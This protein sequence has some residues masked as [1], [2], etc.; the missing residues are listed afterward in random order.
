[1]IKKVTGGLAHLQRPVILAGGKPVRQRAVQ[2]EPGKHIRRRQGGK[3]AQGADPEPA[4]QI[5]QRWPLQRGDRQVSQE[6]G[7]ATGWD[8]PAAAG[9]QQGGEHAVFS[10][11]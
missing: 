4:Q 9:G 8:D 6:A 3:L 5:R 7:R 2:A 1:M 10:E 11:L